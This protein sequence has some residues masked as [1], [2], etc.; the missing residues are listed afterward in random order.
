MGCCLQDAVADERADVLIV[1]KMRWDRRREA[2]DRHR[3]GSIVARVS[4]PIGAERWAAGIERDTSA[5]VTNL[6]P[7]SQ[8]AARNGSAPRVAAERRKSRSVRIG[9]E[10]AMRRRRLPTPFRLSGTAGPSATRRGESCSTRTLGNQPGAPVKSVNQRRA[11]GSAETGW[12]AP[13]DGGETKASE[14]SSP[15]RRRSSGERWRQWA[16]RPPLNLDADGVDDSWA[17]MRAGSLVRTR[18]MRR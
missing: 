3:L 13:D 17:S 7:G 12:C 6:P 10:A 4:P 14:R 18:P 11:T 16:S 2:D 1:V 8:A 15:P 9:G 5:V